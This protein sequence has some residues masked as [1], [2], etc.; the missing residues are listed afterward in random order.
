M[1]FIL[2]HGAGL[3]A[4]AWDRVLPELALP[5]LAVDL[6]RRGDATRALTSLSLEDYIASVA[7]QAD[8]P[9]EE[10][11]VLV[12]HSIGGE[13][14]LGVA[15]RLGSRVAGVVLVSAVVPP[16]G[17]SMLSLQPWLRRLFMRLVLKFGPPV[18]PEKVIRA[19]G[20]N[21]LDEASCRT[22]I[23]RYS[24]ESPRI[25]LDPLVWAPDELPPCLYVKTLQDRTVLPPIQDLMIARAK[26]KRVETLQAGHMPMFAEPH[27]LA[28]ILNDFASS[29]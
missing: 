25:F 27:G 3:G 13:I 15:R 12:G 6:P 24:P 22:L 1:K 9:Q 7:E 19:A 23:E 21:D 20:C 4:W 16:P 5:A 10:K 2:I 17:K 14:A 18:P 11:L 8:G 28:A 26:P 29:L